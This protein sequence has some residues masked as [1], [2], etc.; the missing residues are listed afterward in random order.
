MSV[1]SNNGVMFFTFKTLFFCS[2]SYEQKKYDCVVNI[3]KTSSLITWLVN[4]TKLQKNNSYF[5]MSNIL[6]KCWYSVYTQFST[7]NYINHSLPSPELKVPLVK[8]WKIYFLNLMRNLNNM[9]LEGLT[10]SF[11]VQRVKSPISA[12][13]RI[14]YW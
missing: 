3:V 1:L 8:L 13:S 7:E 6:L 4:L 11:P 9:F 14:K 10:Y 5:K 2:S 12:V